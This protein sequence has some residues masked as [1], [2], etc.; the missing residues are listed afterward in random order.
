MSVAG[1]SSHLIFMVQGRLKH[2]HLLHKWW[3]LKPPSWVTAC[4]YSHTAELQSQR[5]DI[6]YIYDMWY[7]DI[8]SSVVVSAVQTEQRFKLGR[9]RACN[10]YWHRNKPQ[11][12][13]RYSGIKVLPK[14]VAK[15]LKLISEIQIT[16]KQQKH[17]CLL[18][19]P[20]I[21]PTWTVTSV[22]VKLYLQSISNGG[23]RIME[24]SNRA[25]SPVSAKGTHS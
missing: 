7:I 19:W 10:S 9:I 2:G 22:L 15:V 17:F 13:C 11:S 4:M 24:I 23:K 3:E 5:R 1:E 12:W 14:A 18:L 21:A 8:N 25:I 16:L 20:S 6:W